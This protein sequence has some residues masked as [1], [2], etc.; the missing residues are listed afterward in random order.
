[1]KKAISIAFF[2]AG[3]IAIILILLSFFPKYQGMLIFLA[4]FLLGDMIL[5]LMSGKWINKQQPTI[6][7][8]LITF[9]W[10]PSATLL[11]LVLFGFIKPFTSWDVGVRAILMSLLIVTIPAKLIPLIFSLFSRLLSGLISVLTKTRNH[12]IKGLEISGWIIGGSLWSLLLLGMLFWVFSF[13]VNTVDFSSARI[14]ASFDKFRIVQF[15]D[16]H[17]GNWTCSK[18]LHE[19]VVMINNLKPDLIVFTGDMFTFSTNEADG[20]L[21]V[22]KDLHARFGII[23]VM[24]N[25][26]YGDYVRWESD[27]AKHANIENL[28]RFYSDLQWTLLQNKSYVI[29]AG[30][31]SMNIIGVE[32]WGANRRFQR[33][34]DINRAEKGINT[35]C[36]SVLLSHDPSYWDSIIS[37]QHPEV[38]LTLSGHT[39]GG[40]FGVECKSCTWSILSVSNPLWGGMFTK[41]KAGFISSLYV[42][43]GLGVVGYSGRIGIRPEITLFI[44]HSVQKST[45]TNKVAL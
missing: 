10:L 1:M 37:K 39:H 13:K 14:P 23:A 7:L 41:N 5:W 36:F 44:L 42:N 45:Y 2:S 26:D 3:A 31:D 11:C 15:S 18:K 29:H 24:G 28:R 43:R 25:H 16:V 33:L 8:L 27:S 19:A 32:N 20:F 12:R 4:V 21:S 40:Q 9:Y 22:L 30:S 35:A 34:G 17:L 6:R 38:D